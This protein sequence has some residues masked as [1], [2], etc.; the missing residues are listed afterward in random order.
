MTGRAVVELAAPCRL[1]VGRPEYADAH[2]Q[3]RG[4][5]TITIPGPGGGSFT[6]QRCDCPCHGLQQGAER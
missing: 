3:C 4:T 2:A 6:A 5:E 1:A